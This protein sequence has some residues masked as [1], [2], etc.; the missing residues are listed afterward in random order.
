[1]SSYAEVFKAE[2]KKSFL[3]EQR[4]GDIRIDFKVFHTA[5]KIV[6]DDPQISKV[7]EEGEDGYEE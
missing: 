2:L 4:R 7:K 6:S 3:A 1:M 5:D